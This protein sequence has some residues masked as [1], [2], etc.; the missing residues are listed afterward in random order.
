MNIKKENLISL[1]QNENPYGCSPLVLKAISDNYHLINRYPERYPWALKNKLA[2]KYNIIPQKVTASA[3]LVAM[4]ELIIKSFTKYDEEIVTTE[5]TFQAYSILSKINR[6]KCRIANLTDLSV[7]IDNLLSLCND[8]TGVLFIANPNNPTG[9]IITHNDLLRL[10][11]T[12]DPRIFVVVDEAYAEYVTDDKYPDS[13][14]L[15]QSFPNLIIL[16]TFSKI[17]GLAGLRIGYAI[18]NEDTIAAIEHYKAPFSLNLLGSIAAHAALDDDEFIK[19]CI[20]INTEGRN[21]IYE[22]L[23]NCEFHTE[24]SNANFI[25]IEFNG[26]KEK[27][28]IYNGLLKEN[29]LVRNLEEFN[30]SHSLRISI[31]TEEINK[32][33]VKYFQKYF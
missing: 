24:P 17:Y 10:L 26:K 29:I 25:Y 15:Q 23:S 30:F 5:K 11:K 22:A 18:A 27:E 1:S 33:L 31:G 12:I 9:T 13:F 14:L 32:I 4:I 6:R 28:K 21:F 16:R 8:K 3:G 20:T 19:K 7:D 2:E